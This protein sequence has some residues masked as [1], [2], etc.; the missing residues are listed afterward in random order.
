M[1]PMKQEV[2]K[3]SNWSI[4]S[5][6]LYLWTRYFRKC[7][8]IYWD[9][10]YV[11]I[12]II[13]K[14]EHGLWKKISWK[15]KMIML[16]SGTL[17]SFSLKW[18]HGIYKCVVSVRVHHAYG[19]P[20]TVYVHEI[21]NDEISSKTKKN[22]YENKIE[23]INWGKIYW[24]VSMIWFDFNSRSSNLWIWHNMSQKYVKWIIECF[25]LSI[26]YAELNSNQC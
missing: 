6:H 14:A 19:K 2:H 17:L 21:F 25:S 10:M 7:H 16:P 8:A 5:T 20:F 4:Q 12:W 23:F 22:R 18:F 9:Q 24:K 11:V 3:G 1:K 26:E 15:S 13:Q